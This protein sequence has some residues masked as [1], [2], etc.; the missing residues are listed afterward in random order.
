MSEDDDLAAFR[1]AMSDVKALDD[2]HEGLFRERK[3]PVPLNLGDGSN[4]ED[5]VA[6]LSVDVPDFFEFRRP[7]IQ[8]RVFQDLQ[9]G[10]I[11]PEEKLDLHGMR[12]KEAKSA[13]TR[14]MQQSIAKQRRCICIIHGK[15]LGSENNQPVI[16][17]KTYHWLIQ[18]E[19]VLAFVTA[20]SWDGGSGATYALLSRKYRND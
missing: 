5:D 3:K 19:F 8:I 1:K 14:F 11:P 2:D 20:P 13:F 12:V 17:Q 16:K 6:D 7:G 9:R 18:K 10:V 15:G 4:E